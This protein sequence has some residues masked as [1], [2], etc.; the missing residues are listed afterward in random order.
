[1]TFHISTRSQQK[2][3][4]YCYAPHW[5]AMTKMHVFN[6][7]SCF[8]DL[9]P[10]LCFMWFQEPGNNIH[11]ISL[12]V[13]FGDSHFRN[14]PQGLLICWVTTSLKLPSHPPLP[15]LRDTSWRGSWFGAPGPKTEVYSGW[16]KANTEWK[17]VYML[18]KVPKASVLPKTVVTQPL[19]LWVWRCHSSAHPVTQSTVRAFHRR[20]RYPQVPARW[21]S[22][23]V[24][25][26]AYFA[27][28]VLFL[29]KQNQ[30]IALHLNN[31]GMFNFAQ[32]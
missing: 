1:M 7:S 26:K 24:I 31:L 3:S 17:Q 28:P 22:P 9:V 11:Q 25:Q 8:C 10:R 27:R 18:V 6:L 15:F 30:K 4:F 2:C 12:V 5:K 14:Q 23:E 20:A 16:N 21:A 19:K 29:K 13:Q 32:R